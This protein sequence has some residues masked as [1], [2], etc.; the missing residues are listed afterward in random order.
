MNIKI[1]RLRVTASAFFGV[2]VFLFSCSFFFNIKFGS[3]E[4]ICSSVEECDKKKKAYEK[5]IELKQAQQATLGGQ[6]N[7]IVSEIQNV[8][9]NIV[10]KEKSLEEINNNIEELIRKISQQEESIKLQKKMLGGLLRAYYDYDQRNVISLVLNGKGFSAASKNQD[11]LTQA[12]GKVKEILSNIKSLKNSTEEDKKKLEGSREDIVSIK[13]ELEEKNSYL[14]SAKA[15][16]R[17]LLAQVQGDEQK[18]RELLDIIENEIYELE[19]GKIADLDKLPPAKGGYFDYPV[20]SVRITQGYGMTSFAKAGAYGGKPHNGVDFGISYAPIYAAGNGKVISSGNNGKYAYGNWIAIDHGDGLVTLYGHLSKK[21]AS[22]GDK[23]KKGEKIGISG[24]T[25]Y[26]TGPHLHFSVFDKD[27]FGVV[28]SKYVDG[29]YIPT[30]ASVNPM[31][32][33]D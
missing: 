11:Y 3:A 18:Y 6:I 12:S 30:G 15:Q 13:N 8:E 10:E 31:R 16:K 33:L 22:K 5:I 21:S 4:E 26:S 28:E 2:L 19:A 29:L 20:G 25:G 7:G 14:E 23:V 32:Y 9:N 1:K 27:S 24:N 17:N